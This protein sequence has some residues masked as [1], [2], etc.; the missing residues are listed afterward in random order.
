MSDQC[1]IVH[2]GLLPHLSYLCD[3][4][5]FRRRPLFRRPP[6]IPYAPALRSPLLRF[7]LHRI[8]LCNPSC[9][10]RSP[11][12]SLPLAPALPCYCYPSGVPPATTAPFCTVLICHPA[13]RAARPPPA[14]ASNL[15][16]P[17][18]PC[19]HVLSLLSSVIPHTCFGSSRGAAADAPFVH[20]HTTHVRFDT[21]HCVPCASCAL[22]PLPFARSDP[23]PSVLHDAR[24]EPSG[25]STSTLSPASR[26]PPPSVLRDAMHAWNPAA[27]PPLICLP[28]ASTRTQH[29]P[30]TPA[31]IRCHPALRAAGPAWNPTLDAPLPPDPLAD[32]SSSY[33]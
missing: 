8:R 1:L 24:L 28:Y 7:L 15:S 4:P 10:F 12:G 25:H 29:A 30:V 6:A 11:T 20:L 14:K 32:S 17:C 3:H 2:S 9:L 18:P 31:L 22:S 21:T 5:L 26:C 27:V 33:P 23:P 16:C 13:L 19:P